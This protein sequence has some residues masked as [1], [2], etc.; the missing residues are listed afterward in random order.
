MRKDVDRILSEK[1]I[2]SMLFYSESYKNVN[3]YYLSGFLAPDPFIFLKKLGEEPLLVVNQMELAR[4]KKESRVK[5]VRSY[6][7]YDY[8]RI[9]KSASNPKTGSLKFVAAVAKKELGVDEPIYVPPSLPV[10]L[11]DAL[12]DEGLK[13]EPLFDIV[14]KARETKEP[15]EIANIKWVQKAVEKAT[16]KAIELIKNSEVEANKTLTYRENGKKKLLTSG[17]VR[18]VFDHTF[19]DTGCVAEEETIIACGPSGADPHY[20]GRADD[21]LKA[22][23]PIVI[24]VFPKSVKNR[25]VSDMTR[26]IVKG[27]ASKTVKKMFEAVLDTKNAAMDAIKAGVL[28]S[29]MQKLCCDLLERAGYQT[30]RGGKQISKG[31]LHSLGHGIGLEVHEGP[32]MN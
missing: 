4:A 23:Q 9:V 14:E 32:G 5:N 12:R 22:N 7:D 8:I 3:M 2:N 21:V 16:S 11:A 31:Y 24:D 6:F 25:Y 26:T 19:A 18:S 13:I 30:I 17:K 20:A 15:D 1:N 27:K 28:G 29:D 10:V